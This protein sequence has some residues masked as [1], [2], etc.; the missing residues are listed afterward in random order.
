M[1]ALKN[2]KRVTCVKFLTC[3]IVAEVREIVPAENGG[4]QKVE[5][6]GQQ[7]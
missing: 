7:R 6:L 4:A 1:G 5:A 2:S 3:Q